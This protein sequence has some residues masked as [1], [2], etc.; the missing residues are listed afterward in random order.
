MPKRIFIVYGHYNTDK[1]FNAAIRDVFIKEAEKCGHQIDL[2]NL[3][4][5]KQINFFDGS[6]P[7]D[8]ILDYRNR[9]EKSDVMFLTNVSSSAFLSRR[10]SIIIISLIEYLYVRDPSSFIL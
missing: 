7:N 4:K 9:L 8:Q 1:S 2:I 10:A 6:P 3:H 5:E